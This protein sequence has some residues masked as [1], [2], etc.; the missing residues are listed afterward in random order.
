L[1]VPID[2]LPR[3]WNVLRGAMSLVGRSPLIL[4]EHA[5]IHTWGERRLDVRPGI[6]G[7]WQV[8]R[9]DDIPFDEMVK[10]VYLYVTSWSIGGDVRLLLRTLPLLVTGSPSERP[11]AGSRSRSA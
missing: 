5:H 3:L 9:R 8:L 11:L 4:D 10:L 6:T 2:E 7:L 1:A